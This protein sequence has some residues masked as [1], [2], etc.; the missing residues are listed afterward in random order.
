[1]ENHP[2]LQPRHDLGAMMIVGQSYLDIEDDI[3][4]LGP[5]HHG[6]QPKL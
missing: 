3:S 5:T 2:R 4:S 1:M 6:T